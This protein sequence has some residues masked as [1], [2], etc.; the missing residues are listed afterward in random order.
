MPRWGV[1]RHTSGF[2]RPLAYSHLPDRRC[3]V[4][5]STGRWRHEDRNNLGSRLK[6][7]NQRNLHFQAMLVGMGLGIA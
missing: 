2:A 6:N 1:G 3:E 5:G 7:L 4:Q